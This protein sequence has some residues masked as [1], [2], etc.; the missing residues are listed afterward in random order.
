MGQ[1]SS[2]LQSW[3]VNTDVPAADPVPSPIRAGV[4]QRSRGDDPSLAEG[5]RWQMERALV[6]A[7]DRRLAGARLRGKLRA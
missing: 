6:P 3:W 1:I 5:D 2:S 7:V 4:L